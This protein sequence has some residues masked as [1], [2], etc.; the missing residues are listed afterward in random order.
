METNRELY[1]DWARRAPFCGLLSELKHKEWLRKDAGHLDGSL[2]HNEYL[3]RETAIAALEVQM[4]VLRDEINR[5]CP[6]TE[7][8]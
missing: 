7:T 3:V 2:P 6:P 5:R 1:R 8:A 4:S